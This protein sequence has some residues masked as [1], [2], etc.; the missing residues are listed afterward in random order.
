MQQRADA[1]ISAPVPLGT[2]VVGG[3][4]WMPPCSPRDNRSRSAKHMSY[5]EPRCARARGQVVPTGGRVSS[6]PSERI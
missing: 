1:N 4:F 6:D 5:L 2:P 3:S